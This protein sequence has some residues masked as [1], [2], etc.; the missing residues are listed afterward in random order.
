M[1]QCAPL[2][3]VCLLTQAKFRP[4]GICSSCSS[5]QHTLLVGVPPA[6]S[7]SL[8]PPHQPLDPF[9]PRGNQRSTVNG[10]CVNENDLSQTD[11]TVLTHQCKSRGLQSDSCDT[12]S[13]AVRDS[14][15]TTSREDP[16]GVL[17]AVDTHSGSQTSQGDSCGVVL[18]AMD[19]H[20][21]SQISQGDSSGSLT[22]MDTRC[23]Y[24][25][26]QDVLS[27]LDTHCRSQASEGDSSGI[28]SAVDTQFR[29]QG[30][31]GSIPSAVDTQF[32]SQ[33]DSSSILSAMYTQCRS[34]VPGGGYSGE[35]SAV[36]TQGRFQT[37]QGDSGTLEAVDTP[38]VSQASPGDS[39]NAF[40]AVESQCI[41]Q[42]SQGDS[43]NAFSAVESQCIS[44]G[45]RGDSCNGFSAVGSQCSCT[46]R[47][48][49]GDGHAGRC[50]CQPDVT[51]MTS[52]ELQCYASNQETCTTSF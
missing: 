42:G 17:S 49:Q 2:C 29:S 35:L 3:I 30:D 33:G 47:A 21:T 16:D 6:G 22:A 4:V 18:S 44:Q 38:C 23:R 50:L 14:L 1:G 8:S 26:D 37:H 15:S 46:Y 9:Q 51:G 41:S 12:V 52:G 10:H 34:Q 19:T 7:S 20:N 40:S 28:P 36:D 45:S 31:S 27:A 25:A 24:E 5:S 13:A 48:G 39:C 11:A 32:R 43:C